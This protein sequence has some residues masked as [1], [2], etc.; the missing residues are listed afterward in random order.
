L[1]L[2]IESS[3]RNDLSSFIINLDKSKFTQVIRNLLSNAIKFSPKDSTIK[4]KLRIIS[5][6]IPSI[7]IQNLISIRPP[8]Y[9]DSNFYN[10]VQLSVIDEGIGISEVSRNFNILYIHITLNK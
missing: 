1:R 8:I 3:T 10:F 7:K 9:T 2:E 5:L 6:P 4:V